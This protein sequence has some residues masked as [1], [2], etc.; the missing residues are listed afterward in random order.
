MK[1][2][3]K[4]VDYFWGEDVGDLLYSLDNRDWRGCRRILRFLEKR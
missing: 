1:I 4:I 2:K 3:Y